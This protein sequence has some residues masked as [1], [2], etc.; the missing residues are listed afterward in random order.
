MAILLDIE[1]TTTPVAFVYET[2]FPYAR[3][4]LREFL[5]RARSTGEARSELERLKAEHDEEL[6]ASKLDPPRWPA[7]PKS[8]DEDPA[9]AYVLWLMAKDRKSVGLKGL[10]GKIWEAG[11]RE[12]RLRGEVFPDVPPAF[13]RWARQGRRIAIFS[14]G[15]IL[16][17][18]LLFESVAGG[19]SP[20][21]S[22]YFD[23]TIG[24]K[25]DPASYR[26]IAERLDTPASRILFVS[27]TEAELDAARAAGLGTA[28]RE[29]S[30]APAGSPATQG[31]HARI[32]SFD[33]IP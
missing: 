4:H 31:E 11:Y 9:E 25:L 10:Q 19:L 17:Q 28:L 15:S 1:G 21:I 30:G 22:A 18:R 8:R 16:A 2:L 27:D 13:E 29:R 23:T 24:S 3:R 20:S 26:H 5:G 6:A 33:E 12:G 14:S 32:A 7:A